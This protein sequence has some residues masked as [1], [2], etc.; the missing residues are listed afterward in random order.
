MHQAPGMVAA[1][2]AR[3][4]LHHHHHHQHG[5]VSTGLFLPPRPVMADV[6]DVAA[7]RGPFTGGSPLA[8]DQQQ[9]QQQQQQ[10]DRAWTPHPFA[11]R[12]V[13]PATTGASVPLVGEEPYAAAGAAAAYHHHPGREA[14]A[15]PAR[16]WPGRADPYQPPAGRGQMPGEF[17]YVPSGTPGSSEGD[18]DGD[19]E[20]SGEGA[21]GP[22]TS[23]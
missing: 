19:D 4:G 22:W 10:G 8:W 16:F 11:P 3:E 15:R 13:V 20:A 21:Q 7:S 23:G 9:Q 5:A 2:A 12:A 6:A 1:P 18:D 17:V 14:S